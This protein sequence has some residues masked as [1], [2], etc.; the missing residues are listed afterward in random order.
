M[1]PGRVD[2][3]LHLTT[4]TL[5]LGLSLER[6]ER[7]LP[8]TALREIPHAPPWFSGLLDLGGDGLGVMDLM[9]FLGLGTPPPYTLETPIVILTDGDGPERMGLIVPE[10]SGVDRLQDAAL[11]RTPLFQDGPAPILGLGRTKRELVL[12][13]DVD[14]L[15][16]VRLNIHDEE[17]ILRPEQI[18]RLG[19]RM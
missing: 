17:R 2:L 10:V 12:I 16:S 5:H 19:E 11:E 13:L 4:P 14:R 18:Q 6:V 8:L 15:L 9:L 3:I 7:V 1:N